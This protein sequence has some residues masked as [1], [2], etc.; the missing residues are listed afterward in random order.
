MLTEYMKLIFARLRM[1][2]NPAAAA[3]S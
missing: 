3:M 2:L 1:G